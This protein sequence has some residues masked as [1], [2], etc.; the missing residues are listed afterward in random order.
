MPTGGV[1]LENVNEWLDN[2]AYAVG[3]GSVLTK[4]AAT[5]DFD[6]VEAVARQFVDAVK[7]R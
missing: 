2:G 7:N 6:Q 4:G 3:V 5:G 1:S